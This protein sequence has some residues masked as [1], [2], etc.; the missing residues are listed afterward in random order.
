MLDPFIF[1]L[2]AAFPTYPT[3][4]LFTSIIVSPR[5]LVSEYTHVGPPLYDWN[6][7]QDLM[8]RPLAPSVPP[9]A[10]GA[11]TGPL[12]P[13]PFFLCTC[14]R[15]TT[16]LGRRPIRRL[17][18]FSS[19]SEFSWPWRRRRLPSLPTGQHVRGLTIPLYRSPLLVSSAFQ[20][21]RFPQRSFD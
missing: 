12:F 14:P 7:I 13:L 19:L 21:S 1:C 15:S 6:L 20:Q 4:F 18:A 17:V 10:F 8:I 5:S 11:G 16:S 3:P 2:L 9:M